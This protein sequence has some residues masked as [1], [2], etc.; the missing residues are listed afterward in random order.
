[1]WNKSSKV[2]ALFCELVGVICLEGHQTNAYICLGHFFRA[3]SPQ[4][5]P[6]KCAQVF[7]ALSLAPIFVVFPFSVFDS[8]AMCWGG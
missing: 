2:R 3:H 6:E 7:W 4:A 8:K 5:V 1:V